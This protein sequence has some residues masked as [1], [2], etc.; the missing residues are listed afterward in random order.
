MFT[1]QIQISVYKPFFT[2][3][4][5]FPLYVSDEPCVTESISYNKVVVSSTPWHS[6]PPPVLSSSPLTIPH[7]AAGKAGARSANGW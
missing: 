3:I 1:D 6:L 4:F 2:C 7:P 5:L